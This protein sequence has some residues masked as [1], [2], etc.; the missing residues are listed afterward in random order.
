MNTFRKMGVIDYTGEI[1]LPRFLPPAHSSDRHFLHWAITD[2]SVP[3]A[4]RVICDFESQMP[5]VPSR[6]L[7]V[8]DHSLLHVCPPGGTLCNNIIGVADIACG[9]N[10]PPFA[11]V[12]GESPF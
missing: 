11:Q 6:A 9:H 3:I 12:R 2:Q 7:L 5:S 4:Q 8:H 10:Q 1:P